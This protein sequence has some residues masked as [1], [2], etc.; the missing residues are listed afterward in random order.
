MLESSCLK[1]KGGKSYAAAGRSWR[2]LFACLLAAALPLW[3]LRPVLARDELPPDNLEAADATV[4]PEGIV[5][6]YGGILHI[7]SLVEGQE[8]TARADYMSYDTTTGQASLSGNVTLALVDSELKLECD[9]L[10]YDPLISLMQVGGLRAAL[11]LGELM[12]ETKQRDAEPRAE[13]GNH[14]YVSTPEQVYLSAQQAR[15]DFDPMHREFVLRN[16]RFSH[17]SLADPDLYVTAR[18]ARFSEDQ[19]LKLKGL[20]LYISGQRILAWPSY[21]RRYPPEPSWFSLNLPHF[22]LGSK[23]GV[24]WK[25]GADFDFG[26][27]KARV[28]LD[29]SPAYG[30][31]TYGHATIEPLPGTQLGIAL[32]SRSE[33]D[34][35][36]ASIDRHDLYNFIF[37]QRTVFGDGPVR[38]LQLDVEYG[39]VVAKTEAVPQQDLPARRIEDKRLKATGVLNFP[40]V[41]LGR[42]LYLTSAAN[43]TYARYEGAGEEYKAVGGQAGLIWRHGGFDHFLLYK[44]QD[45]DGVAI[46]PFDKVR[47]K[48]LDFGTAISLDPRWRSVVQGVYDF[49]ED[50]FN[51]LQVGALR[52]MKTYELGLY[53]DFAREDAGIELGLLMN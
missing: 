1:R 39:K 19:R 25:Q 18:E 9:S 4:S 28:L 32:G 50:S 5:E 21:S 43:A 46:F 41:T 27:P 42:D 51:L 26:V 37:R 3:A 2:L 48:E 8:F 7:T 38:D 34:I 13:L 14:F 22:S 52:K 11:P 23:Q 24:S 31:K 33:V 30:L 15:L 47:A 53:W 36:R 20:A 17:S 49:D 35:D 45:V 6:A 12:A 40:L 10:R 29:Y 16:I 44:S